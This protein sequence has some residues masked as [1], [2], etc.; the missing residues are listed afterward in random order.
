MRTLL[1]VTI[2][3]GIG[4]FLLVGESGAGTINA[5]LTVSNVNLGITGVFA[6]VTVED[7]VEHQVRFTVDAHQALLG[8]GTNFGIQ[9]FLFNID[10]SLHLSGSDFSME[11]VNTYPWSVEFGTNGNAGFGVFSVDTSGNGHSRYDPLT[12]TITNSAIIGVSQFYVGNDGKYHYA[13]HIADFT[14]GP[15]RVDSAWFADGKDF[16]PPPVPEPATLL[17]LGCGLVGL[18]ALKRRRG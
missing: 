18:A 11:G 5:Q 10:A 14:Q 2:L 12:F 1:K 16:I 17:L 6:T 9:S 7:T 8:A 13:A 4:M 15:V 3:L